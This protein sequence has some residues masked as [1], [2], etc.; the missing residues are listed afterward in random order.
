M[1][2]KGICTRYKA[3]KPVGTGRYASGQ[4]RCQICE[5]FIKWEGLWCPCCGYR[6][7]TKPRN[8]KYKAKLRARV[9]ADQLEAV[10][11]KAAEVE[12]IELEPIAVKKSVKK[13]KTAK[14]KTTKAKTVKAT[15]K[16]VAVTPVAI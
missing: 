13:A 6:L 1:T 14:A 3:Q 16:K 2:C 10:A 11:V 12:E 7:R 15:I 8:L 9:E 5:I 4:K